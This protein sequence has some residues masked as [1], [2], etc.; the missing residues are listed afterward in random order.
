MQLVR[1]AAAYGFGMV[2]MLL[3]FVPIVLWT[4]AA[5]SSRLLYAVSGLIIRSTLAIGGVRI[6]VVGREHIPPPPFLLVCNHL[7]LIDGPLIVAIMPCDLHVLIK[8]ETLRYPLIGLLFRLGGFVFVDRQSGRSA[9]EALLRTVGRIKGKKEAFLIFPE[10]TR[11]QSGERLPFKKGGFMIAIKAGIPI[12]PARISG[13]FACMPPHTLS[14]HPGEIQVLFRP[15]VRLSD[16]DPLSAESLC[17]H[18][19]SL[20]DGEFASEQKPD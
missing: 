6:S 19:E 13:S 10:G 9:A 4:L 3:I 11:S 20:Y 17:R 15:V 16:V 7:S 5:R 2:S 8:A 12:L 18:V 1:N 14:L